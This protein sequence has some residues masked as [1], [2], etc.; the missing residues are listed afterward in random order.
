MVRRSCGEAGEAVED[1]VA[2]SAAIRGRAHGLA[3]L[4]VV[5]N[6]NAGAF[7]REHDLADGRA[8]PRLHCGFVFGAAG[9]LRPHGAQVGWPRQTADMGGENSFGASFHRRCLAAVCLETWQQ[10]PGKKPVKCPAVRPLPE[11]NQIC[12]F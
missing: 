8:Q 6:I 12:K 10:I 9:F 2:P 5:G 4:A 3:E 11:L 1:V 7:L